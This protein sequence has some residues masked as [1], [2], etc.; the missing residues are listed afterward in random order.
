MFKTKDPPASKTMKLKL[1]SPADMNLQR[2]SIANS[3]R[4]GSFTQ[5]QN[6][7][8]AGTNRRNSTII[9]E[10]EADVKIRLI[11]QDSIDTHASRPSIVDQ[12]GEPH[13]PENTAEM[14]QL[15]IEIFT[16]PEPVY[17]DELFDTVTIKAFCQFL[18]GLITS[19]DREVFF[20]VIELFDHKLKLMGKNRHHEMRM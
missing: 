2:H 16:R 9:V 4:S 7:T 5:T 1:P 3:R 11:S 18:E 17:F 6:S 14:K 8:N 12:L 15:A 13:S 20:K 10:D 19:H